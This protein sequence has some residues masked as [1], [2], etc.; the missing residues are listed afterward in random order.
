MV[1]RQS[2]YKEVCV[3]VEEVIP[4]RKG[5]PCHVANCFPIHKASTVGKAQW[6]I[7]PHWMPTHI[8]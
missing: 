8:Q 5:C 6:G 2:M 1:H 4:T 7:C 3:E